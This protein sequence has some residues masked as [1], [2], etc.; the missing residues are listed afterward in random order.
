MKIALVLCPSWTVESP[1]YTLA[2]LSAILRKQGHS[3]K[4]FDLNIDMFRHCD[5]KEEINTWQMDEK[6]V[7]WYEEGYTLDFI[8]R[9]NEYIE[10]IIDNI[11]SYG[12]EVIGFTVYSTSKHFSYEVARRI[13][14]RDNK[15]IIIFGGPQCFKNCEGMDTLKRPYVDAVCFGEGDTTFPNMLDIL[16]K[17]KG[18]IDKCRGFGV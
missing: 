9:H 15:K 17:N 6:G 18:I 5:D 1:P 10:K 2:L 7:C 12:A 13:K 11:F 4:C 14:E 16:I 8:Q 3:V